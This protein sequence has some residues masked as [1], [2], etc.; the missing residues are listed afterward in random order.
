M[1][2][3][4]TQHIT[5]FLVTSVQE[6]WRGSDGYY[7]VPPFYAVVIQ[8]C[9]ACGKY[10]RQGLTSSAGMVGMLTDPCPAYEGEK[11]RVR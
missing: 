10:K 3:L 6:A 4:V 5:L 2:G 1:E 9:T 7:S 11:E 8:V